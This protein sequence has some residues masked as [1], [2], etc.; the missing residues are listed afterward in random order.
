MSSTPYSRAL[1][2]LQQEPRTWLVTGAAGFVGSHLVEALLRAGQRVVGLD[3]FITGRRCNLESL[4]HQLGD[5]LWSSFRFVE[6]DV[7]STEDCAAACGGVDH[8][9]HQAA[10]GSVPRSLKDPLAS[11]AANVDGFLKLVLAARDAGARSVVY[12]SSSSVYGDHP[13]LPK[14]EDAIG[15]P[16]SPYAATKRIDEIYA[17]V[18]HRCYDFPIAG[19]RYFNVVGSRQD[20]NGP[21]AAV[22]PRW[23]SSFLAGEVPEIF[24]DGETSRDF[25]P[26]ENV[27]QANLLAALE[28]AAAG[29]V[30][31]VALGGQTTLNEL[32]FAIRDTLAS[33]GVDC[34]KVEPVYRDFRPGDVR[35]SLANTSKAQEI[36][37]YQPQVTFREGLERTVRW[38]HEEATRAVTPA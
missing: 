17:A 22:I 5:E 10:L 25:C 6:G 16:L 19:M 23:V 34:A 21:Y 29:H 27:V 7:T 9:L 38:F 2:G 35:H 28:P 33:L 11:H 30:F 4:Q 15:S 12:A 13:G 14:V 3:N 1:S 20:P 32:F 26:V 31:N 24:G 36:F 37:G 18:V 8:V